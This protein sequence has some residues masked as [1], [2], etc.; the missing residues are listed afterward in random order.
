[1]ALAAIFP[2]GL[3]CQGFIELPHK[4][5]DGVKPLAP[6]PYQLLHHNQ[7]GLNQGFP[8]VPAPYQQRPLKQG[9]PALGHL[10]R[11]PAGS[12]IG[13]HFEHQMIMV[14]HHRIG[15]DADGKQTR[16]LAQLVDYPLAPVLVTLARMTIFPTQKARRTQRLTTW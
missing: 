16:Q 1:M 15:A 8:L 13:F 6:L 12:C 10:P 11:A 2:I 14:A 9:S 3:P 4:P 7:L 5:A